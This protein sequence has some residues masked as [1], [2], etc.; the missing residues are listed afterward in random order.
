MEG[1]MKHVVLIAGLLILAAAVRMAYISGASNNTLYLTG[2]TAALLG[3]RIFYD[4]FIKMKW[5]NMALALSA[6]LAFILIGFIA[7][8][9]LRGT[10][11]YQEDAVIVLGGG[12]RNG[13]PSLTLALRLDTAYNYYVKNPS[14]PIIVSGG[15]G[16][17]ETV[18][19]GLAMERYLVALGVPE[20]M[21]YKEE[22]AISTYTNMIY[23]KEILDRLFDEEPLVTVITSDFH[24]FRSS[25]FA[26]RT[27]INHT[28]LPAP[29][30]WH[31]LPANYI[32]EAGAVIKLWLLGR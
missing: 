20:S 19:E 29:T 13:R 16:R 25:R 22:A 24:I 6:F 32:R 30:P 17:G 1:F 28:Y 4:R 26:K 21:I 18:T 7:A 31:S 27:E 14:A 8:F 23:S 11:T 5:L 12:L 9:G 15:L 10:V 2:F 3:Y